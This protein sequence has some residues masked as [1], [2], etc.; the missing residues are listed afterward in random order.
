MASI[1]SSTRWPTTSATSC[2]QLAMPNA[3]EPWSLTNL[4]EKLIR[5]SAKVVSHSRYVMFQM[6]D[7]AVS[8]QMFADIL[9][10]IALLRGAARAG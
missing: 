4:R 7:V 3:V 10:L 9:M 2:G 6:A 8:R 5:I 1:F